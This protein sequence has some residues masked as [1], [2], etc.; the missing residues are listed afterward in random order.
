MLRIFLHQPI[1]IME[2]IVLSDPELWKAILSI[3]LNPLFWNIV[4]QA[5]Y[6][7]HTM[8][9]IFCNNKK[10]SVIILGIIILLLNGV[11]SYYFHS[12][13]NS[14]PQIPVS[15]PLVF[16]IGSFLALVGQFFVITSFYK[17]GFYP[18]FLGDHF[19]IFIHEAPITTFPFSV[20]S[21]PMYW[22]S[23]LTY[24][25]IAVLETSFVGIILTAWI[26]IVYQLAII[27]ESKML[28][29]IYSKKAA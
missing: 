19:G 10:L 11:R 4:G 25:G 8:S 23:A 16:I 2:L 17:L 7:N 26:A 5:E 15:H 12:A 29:I 6:Y 9:K 28:R 13:I 21:D 22:G 14:Q 18:T 20:I 1:L 3:A 27:H 24:L